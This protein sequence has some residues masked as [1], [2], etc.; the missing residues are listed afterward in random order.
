[1]TVVLMPPRWN[2]FLN[3]K[4][5]AQRQSCS[6]WTLMAESFFLSL[7]IWEVKEPGVSLIHLFFIRKGRGSVPET[8]ESTDFTPHL[9]RLVQF[10]WCCAWL[11]RSLLSLKKLPYLHLKQKRPLLGMSLNED[12]DGSFNMVVV[13]WSGC[14]S[15]REWSREVGTIIS[16]VYSTVHS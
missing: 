13:W 11:L 8:W 5:A 2:R 16:I 7:E 3:D 4:K 12:A 9:E 14:E 6:S 10:R 15:E 1:M